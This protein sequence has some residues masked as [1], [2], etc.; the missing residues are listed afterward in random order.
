MKKE[1]AEIKKLKN[2]EIAKKL[3]LL[4]GGY[5][6]VDA[7]AYITTSIYRWRKS[8]NGYVHARIFGRYQYLHRF[9]LNTPPGKDTDHING[10]KLDN[11]RSNL[12]VCSKAENQRNRFSKRSVGKGVSF[13]KRTGRWLAQITVNYRNIWLG[14][15]DTLGEARAA[16]DA[17]A[18]KYF[19]LFARL[20]TVQPGKNL[21]SKKGKQRV[22][23]RRLNP[24]SNST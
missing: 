1:K 4:N 17:A 15:H 22:R 18:I 12:R 10:N 24:G 13:C 19:G 5:A 14:R 21:V 11:R 2:A 7:D 16:Y 9:I 20:N 23:E 6:I 8:S 3:P